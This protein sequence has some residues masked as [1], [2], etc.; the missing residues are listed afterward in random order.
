VNLVL[1]NPFR[2]LGLPASATSREIARRVSDLSVDVAVGHRAS[3]PLDQP[4]WGEVHRTASDIESAASAVDDPEGR[5][6]YGL[7]WFR[8]FDAIDEPC[9][10]GIS[11]SLAVGA[12]RC[13]VCSTVRC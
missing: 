7:F 10:Y 11:V 9:V 1:A 2:I 6:L 3:F 13:L 12:M 8:A 5:W 4:T